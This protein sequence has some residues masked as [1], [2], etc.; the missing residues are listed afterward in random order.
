MKTKAIVLALAGLGLT[1]ALMA[2]GPQ[3]RGEGEQGPYGMHQPGMGGPGMHHRGV[4]DGNQMRRGHRKGMMRRMARALD[5]TS[6]QRQQFR[7]LFKAERQAK[8]AERKAHRQ[9]GKKGRGMF[10]NLNPETF[11]SADHFDKEA[12]TKAVEKQAQQRRAERQAKR[13]SRLEHRAAFMEKI[14]NIL[15]PEQ[16]VKWIELAKKR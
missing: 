3:E 15:T 7:A 5:L 9:Q 4:R 12:F 6:E 1:T 13:Q 8:K 14:F 2:G 10:G 16:R 11:M